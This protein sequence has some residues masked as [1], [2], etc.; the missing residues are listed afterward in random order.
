MRRE[1]L[2]GIM[3]PEFPSGYSVLK[4][5]L[6]F[7]KKDDIEEQLGGSSTTRNNESLI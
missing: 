2:Y 5:R 1:F 4:R 3:S 7:L 6:F